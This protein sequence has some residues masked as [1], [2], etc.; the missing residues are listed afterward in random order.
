MTVRT[1]GALPFVS[2]P[3]PSFAASLGS[4]SYIIMNTTPPG[5]SERSLQ[6]T[7]IWVQHA[8]DGSKFAR[9]LGLALDRSTELNV[10]RR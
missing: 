5:T 6:S 10:H 9:L 4:P 2:L 1:R 7:V 8:L 3:L